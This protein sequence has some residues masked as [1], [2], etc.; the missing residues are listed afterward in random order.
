MANVSKMGFPIFRLPILAIF[1]V[2]S[3]MNPLEMI[4]FSMSSSKCKRIVK[5]F[6]CPGCKFELQLHIMDG[7]SISFKGTPTFWWEYELTLEKNEDNIIKYD[8]DSEKLMKYS[9]NILESF[10]NLFKYIDDL[11]SFKNLGFLLFEMN[12]FPLQNDLIIQEIKNFKK[13]I[14]WFEVFSEEDVENDVTD[15]LNHVKGIKHLNLSAPFSENFELICP[16]SLSYL[17]I[18]N[19]KWVNLKKLLEFSSTEI[20][21]PKSELTDMDLCAFFQSW[22]ASE[23][24]SNLEKIEIHTVNPETFVTVSQNLPHEEF[25][26]SVVRKVHS[27][28]EWQIVLE[29]FSIKR[30]DGTWA[31]IYLTQHTMHPDCLTLEMTVG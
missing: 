8:A 10:F 27:L 11:M 22:I 12:K 28:P 21:I 19:S 3:M 2:F 7:T 14:E 1:N 5:Q 9:T 23:S 6:F 4:N 25:D 30:N 26:N 17:S 15:I 29:S 31:T 13:P 18:S 24:H 20:R 16:P